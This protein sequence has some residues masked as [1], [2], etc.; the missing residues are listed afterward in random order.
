MTTE[1][2][3]SRSTL[4]GIGEIDAADLSDGTIGVTL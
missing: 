1:L 2:W 4:E 3:L